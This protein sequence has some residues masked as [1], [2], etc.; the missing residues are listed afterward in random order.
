MMQVAMQV[1][2]QL[3]TTSKFGIMAS[4]QSWESVNIDSMMQGEQED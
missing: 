3:L 2:K 4:K 1:M